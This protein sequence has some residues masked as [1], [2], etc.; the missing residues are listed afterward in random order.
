MFSGQDTVDQQTMTDGCLN[1]LGNFG[2]FTNRDKVLLQKPKYWNRP[3][4][5]GLPY[6]FY[7]ME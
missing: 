4:G 6:K 5:Q 1:I 2:I 3:S 7:A